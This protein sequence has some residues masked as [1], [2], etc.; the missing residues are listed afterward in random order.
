M[1]SSLKEAHSGDV[2]EEPPLTSKAV[3]MV[4]QSRSP[5]HRLHKADELKNGY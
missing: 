1:A 4:L 5:K 2:D 3:L